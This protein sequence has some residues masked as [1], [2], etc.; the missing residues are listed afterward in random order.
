MNN[1]KV[2]TKDSSSVL[3]N[4]I[5]KKLNIELAKSKS[6]TFSNGEIG[7]NIEE[8]VRGDDVFIIYSTYSNDLLLELMIMIDALKRASARRITAVI[9]FFGYARQDRKARP[10]EPITAKLVAD[11]LTTAGADRILTIDLH[12]DQIQGFFNI[13]VDHLT[14]IPL[15]ANYFK[16]KL[17]DKYYLDHE[18][19]VVSPDHG[20]VTRSRRFAKQF[21]CDLAIVDK[22]RDHNN[23][24]QSE[25]I[26]IIGDVKDKICILVDDMIDTAGT[27]SNASKALKNNGALNVFACATHPVLSGKCNE[28]MFDSSI[29][30][31]VFTNTI[32]I[33]STITSKYSI[34]SVEQLLA[35]AIKRIHNEESVSELFYA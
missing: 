34:V 23:P 18:I 4:N 22:R 10:R 26:N 19:I 25:V 30:E 35:D 1:I 8:S 28:N 9:P 32:P 5:C 16:E 20:G 21:N 15:L 24:N 12:V 13:P 11:L 31:F 7:V 17:C 27:I 2:F 6:F 33:C 3:V 14:A 29:S